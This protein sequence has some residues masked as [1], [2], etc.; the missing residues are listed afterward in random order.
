MSKM[1]KIA[2]AG[3]VWFIST[4]FA[5]AGS[6]RLSAEDARKIIDQVNRE[7]FGGL[8]DPADILAVIEIESGFDPD[9]YRYEPHIDDASIGL[10][11]ILYQVAKDRGYQGGPG[12]LYDPYTNISLGMAHLKWTRDF[13]INRQVYSESAW[14]GAY[15]AGVGNAL[16]GRYVQAYVDKWRAAKERYA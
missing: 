11:Q 8:F 7:Q 4:Q 10:M 14:I 15:N 1:V 12:G 3:L 16:K 2:V 13:L 5:Q 6:R 9:A